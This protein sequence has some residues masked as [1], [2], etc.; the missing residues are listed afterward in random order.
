MNYVQSRPNRK[1][2]V[3]VYP[4]I[5][6]LSSKTKCGSGRG[7]GVILIGSAHAGRE[8]WYVCSHTPLSMPR[9]CLLLYQVVYLVPYYV[10][11]GIYIRGKGNPGMF[12]PVL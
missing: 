11:L 4:Q 8:Y 9:C 7:S 2:L 3:F 6:F 1:L 5:M 12:D 10:L